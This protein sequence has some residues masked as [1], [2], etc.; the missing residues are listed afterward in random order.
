MYVH[1]YVGTNVDYEV[2]SAIVRRERARTG[3]R[4]PPAHILIFGSEN[5]NITQ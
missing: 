4:L 5:E 1:C 2:C 3:D